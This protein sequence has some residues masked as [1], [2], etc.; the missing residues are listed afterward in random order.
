MRGS[1]AR[2][3][4][5]LVAARAL[6]AQESRPDLAS[7]D[8]TELMQMDVEVTTATKSAQSIYDVAAPIFV[9][10]AED[11][12]RAGATSIPEALRLAPGVVVGEIDPGKWIVSPRGFAWEFANKSLILLDG[13]A[14][15]TPLNSSVYWNTLDV[16]IQNIERIEVI[17]GPGDARWGSHAVN[18]IINVIT[19]RAAE[20]HGTSVSALLDTDASTTFTAQHGGS[21]AHDTDYRVYAKYLSDGDFPM[22]DG[23]P[24]LGDR[25]AFRSGVRADSQL[26]AQDQLTFIGDFQSG[27]DTSILPGQNFI[28]QRYN[29]DEWSLMARWDRNSPGRVVQQAQLSFD[30]LQQEIYETRHTFD[31]A[32]Q[33][34]LPAGRMQTLT[35]GATY[36]RSSDWLPASISVYPTSTIQQ[37]YGA[38]LHD[39]ITLGS[40]TRLLLGSQFEHNEYTGWEVQP[41]LQL[42][43]A[44]KDRLAYWASVSRAVRTPLR[45][46][47]GFDL[48]FP[49]FPGGYVRALGN[50]DL[51]SETVNAWQAGVRAGLAEQLF[52]DVSVFYND[53]D[54]LILQR[55]GDPIFTI[56][57]D[58]GPSQTIFP[59]TY[60]NAGG[61]TT[62]GLEVSLETQPFERWNV[63][64]SVSLY[65][66]SE[67][68]DPL[69]FGSFTGVNHQFQLHSNVTLV[70]HLEWN[71]NFYNVGASTLAAGSSYNRL[72]TQLL[73][74]PRDK[75]QVA[76]GVKNAI[77]PDHV[78]AAG[79]SVDA[80]AK[81]PR[82]GYLNVFAQF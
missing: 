47:D 29:A 3:V 63:A 78:E 42:L 58:P 75:W 10:S 54:D 81:I 46:E 49:I 28:P 69:G 31:F 80:I 15:Y 56:L 77:D 64:A 26:T 13:R 72:D 67:L 17:R 1:I 7:L 53:Y 71:L 79:N 48:V 68:S 6:H 44:P 33:A 11:I 50:H 55:A 16:P 35:L 66:Q 5:L 74:T 40:A 57:P 19:K 38:F 82:V 43:Y 37:T 27:R 20:S 45:T 2:C 59:A 73:W 65:H 70:P 62:R 14:V 9:I 41:N 51:R 52:L 76:L 30:R 39:Q 25:T 23:Q 4:A 61:A 22:T 24:R 18:G 34:Q 8:L 21:L 12:R 36:K 32:Y 60:I